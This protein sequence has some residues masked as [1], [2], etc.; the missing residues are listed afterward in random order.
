[1]V[2]VYALLGTYHDLD[3]LHDGIIFELEGN[4]IIVLCQLNR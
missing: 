1:M 4:N 2:N 3:V